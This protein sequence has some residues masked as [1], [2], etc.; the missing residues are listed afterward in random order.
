VYLS[1]GAVYDG[2][3]GTVSPATP[4]SPLL[5]YAI[6][7][8]AS[9]QYVRFFSERR[10][11]PTSYVNVRF[12]GA[13]GPYEPDRKITTRW[14]LA[15]AAGQREFTLRGNGQN[16]ID[17]MY[18]ND[19]VDAFLTLLDRPGERLTVDFASGSPV[20]VNEIVAAMA[21]ALDVN[22]IVRHEGVTEEY[23]T[24][25]SDDRTLRERFGIVPTTTFE[26]GLRQ[27]RTFFLRERERGGKAAEAS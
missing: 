8:L 14:L 9:E 13:Y 4:V 19:A 21:R 10:G 15:L 5:P 26:A 6:S 12:F 1:S 22:V 17:F 24:F 20:S 11:L 18:V 23:I 25:R 16:L 2:L 3:S 27:L 7:K